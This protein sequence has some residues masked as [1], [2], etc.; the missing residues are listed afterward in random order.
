MPAENHTP[1][2]SIDTESVDAWARHALSSNGFG[3]ADCVVAGQGLQIRRDAMQAQ[4]VPAP[5]HVTGAAAHRAF[6]GAAPGRHTLIDEVRGNPRS[7]QA[8]I[9]R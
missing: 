7:D 8:V 3:D 9:A 1:M 5:P 4:D 6:T 2:T